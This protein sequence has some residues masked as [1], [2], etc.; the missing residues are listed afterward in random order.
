M[1]GQSR[2]ILAWRL[3]VFVAAL[4]PILWW[5]YHVAIGAAGPEPGRYLLLNL[6]QGALILLLCTLSLTPLTRLT[7]WK[8]FSVIRR[9]L[10]LWTF[11]YGVLHL[12]CYLLFILGL[13]W[14]ALGEDLQKRPYIIVGA[15]ALLILLALAVTSN[16]Y[17]MRKLGKRWKPLHKAVYLV[18]ALV[19]LHFLWIV[20]ADLTEWSVYAAVALALMLLRIPTVARRLSRLGGQMRHVRA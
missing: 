6:G 2:H 13:N 3:L 19:L 14:T 8:G 7:R 20:R 11:G 10:G 9:Q 17:A 1:A 15:L 12:L 4:A 16:R 18:L 5:S